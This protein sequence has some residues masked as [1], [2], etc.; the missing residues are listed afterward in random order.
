[1][2]GISE[3]KQ[4]AVLLYYSNNIQLKHKYKDLTLGFIF[5]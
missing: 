4:L 5:L 1:M 3:L 2:N